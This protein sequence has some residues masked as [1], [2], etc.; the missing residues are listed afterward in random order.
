MK[1]RL[2][3]LTLSVCVL[4][5]ALVG[6][7]PSPQPVGSSPA[8]SDPAKPSSPYKIEAPEV[9]AKMVKVELLWIKPFRGEKVRL[10]L[11]V[12][13]KSAKQ[14][15]RAKGTIDVLDADGNTLGT[16]STWV[17]H[18]EKGGLAA[19]SSLEED[20]I[21]D[22]SDKTKATSMRFAMEKIRLVRPTSRPAGK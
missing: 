20:S 2:Q 18:G 4:S 16:K 5:L 9:M 19:A 6:C 14:I 21:V 13:N 15:V 17:I 22:V 3:W 8:S 1:R 7:G 11:K 10:M 12:T